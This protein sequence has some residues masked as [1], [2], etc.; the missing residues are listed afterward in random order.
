MK[1]GEF[2]QKYIDANK[3][4][5]AELA[6]RSGVPASTISSII[7]RNNDRVAIEMILKLCEVLGCDINEYINTLKS[8]TATK[9]TKNIFSQQEIKHIKKYRTLDEYGK[10]SVDSILDI[11]FERC[12]NAHH[13]PIFIFRKFSENKVSAGTGFDLNDPDQWRSIEVIDT[14]EARMA[15]FAVEV[16]GASMEPDYFDG[17]IVYIALASEV[18][19]GQVGLFIQNGKGFIKE[20][21]KDCLISRN[22]EYPNISP[23]DGEIECK[24]RVIGVAELPE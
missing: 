11:E 15:D 19:V 23:E 2:L 20:A 21:G 18:P 1:I 6:R 14:P 4:S 9:D 13:K 8:G 16:K 10:K 17:D 24:G 7:N 3:I 12:E 22:K 5:Q